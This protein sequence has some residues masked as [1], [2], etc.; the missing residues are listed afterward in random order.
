MTLL[1]DAMVEELKKAIDLRDYM[2]QFMELRRSGDHYSA[3]CPFHN[4]STPS[5]H[6]W[7][8][9]FHC[10]GCG[11]RGDII[12]YEKH[13]T[14]L[15]FRDAVVS[16]A[17]RHNIT[18]VVSNEQDEQ[19]VALM[20]ERKRLVAIVEAVSEF[21]HQMLFSEKGIEARKYL[22]SRGFGEAYCKAWKLGVAPH[23][24]VLED[25]SKKQSWNLEDVEKAGLLGTSQ[26]GER[27][28]DFF[29]SRIIIP[30]RNERGQ[31][32]GFGGRKYRQED[33][34]NSSVPK[35]INPRETVLYSKSRILFNFDRARAAIVSS[36]DVVVVEGYM[37]ALSLVNA[38]VENV[39]AVS[40]TAMTP[41][42]VK[43]LAKS[44]RRVLLCFDTDAAG[45]KA[46]ERAFDVAFP[47]NLVKLQ[48]LKVSDGKDPDEF[49]RK[50]GGQAFKSLMMQAGSLVEQVTLWA[51]GAGQGSRE[52][53]IRAVR[54]RILPVIE[55]NPDLAQREVAVEL[56]TKV[57]GLSSVHVLMNAPRQPAK[58]SKNFQEVS[59]Q[60]QPF[61][62]GGAKTE[63]GGAPPPRWPILMANEIKLVVALLCLSLSA[64]ARGRPETEG[65]LRADELLREC[66]NL[67]LMTQETYDMVLFVL[68]LLREK[69]SEIAP[70]ELSF[71]EYLEAPV[72]VQVLV[73]LLKNDVLFVEEL[74]LKPWPP[75][76]VKKVV[77][78]VDGKNALALANAAYINFCV[79]DAQLSQKRGS[80]VLY[81]NQIFKDLGQKAARMRLLT[82][83]M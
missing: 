65:I 13:R 41:D 75:L 76:G 37:D 61:D 36:G 73:A 83:R 46:A 50:H 74:G 57:L 63:E 68:F 11:K 43:L 39:V 52:A 2:R 31:V 32:V 5:F 29:R 23:Y 71:V 58:L 59:A 70:F 53:W 6:V 21:Y 9:H 12:E 79:Q 47:M 30:I 51:K 45:Q 4:D 72:P 77:N 35:F 38:G 8:D 44:A 10:F 66:L 17:E 67:S 28:Y 14:G 49:V 69:C 78:L 26:D 19:A 56:V 62:G 80:L 15:S 33:A 40:G 25:L 3:R 42:H 22:E 18:V 24:S 48:F 7:A 82:P 27:K 55:K 60:A 1:N 81:L 16:L 64:D 34:S 54:S 20:A